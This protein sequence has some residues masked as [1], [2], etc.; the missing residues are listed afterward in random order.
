MSVPS[1]C[2]FPF[3]SNIPPP[4]KNTFIYPSVSPTNKSKGNYT[5]SVIDVTGKLVTEFSTDNSKVSIDLS[6]QPKGVYFMQYK[7]DLSVRTAKIIIE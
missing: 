7:N 3:A 1:A 5:I 2:K 6:N 4:F